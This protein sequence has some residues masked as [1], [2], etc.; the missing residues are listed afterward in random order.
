[1][2]QT[3]RSTDCLSPLSPRTASAFTLREVDGLKSE[4]IR[5]LLSIKTSKLWV[6]LHRARGGRHLATSGLLICFIGRRR[7]WLELRM[8]LRRI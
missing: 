3:K 5:E 2:H 4:E 1:M 6:M 8:C 7:S